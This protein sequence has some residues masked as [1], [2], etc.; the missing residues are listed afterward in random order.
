MKITKQGLPASLSVHQ[1]VKVGEERIGKLMGVSPRAAVPADHGGGS[2]KAVA[3]ILHKMVPG[4]LEVLLA[5]ARQS[6]VFEVQALEVFL[7]GSGGSAIGKALAQG[8]LECSCKRGQREAPAGSRG[9]RIERGKEGLRR[10]QE[11]GWVAARNGLR[12]TRHDAP[13]RTYG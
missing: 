6:E 5:S 12:I 4:W 2:A 1:T 8:T 10:V 11:P 7:E 3:V 9:L 13:L